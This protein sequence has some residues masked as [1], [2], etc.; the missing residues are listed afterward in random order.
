MVSE[1]WALA[2]A[3]LTNLRTLDLATGMASQSALRAHDMGIAVRWTRRVAKA[4][5]AGLRQLTHLSVRL[6][7][8]C[9]GILGDM[10][11]PL[12][13]HGLPLPVGGHTT[14][15]GMFI[16]G[17]SYELGARVQHAGLDL[18]ASTLATGCFPRLECLEF[19]LGAPGWLGGGFRLG[20]QLDAQAGSPL[21]RLREL[22]AIDP[23][24][25]VAAAARLPRLRCLTLPVD[26]AAMLTGLLPAL[27]SPPQGGD[28]HGGAAVA[29]TLVAHGNFTDLLAVVSALRGTPVALLTTGGASML[30]KGMNHDK[31]VRTLEALGPHAAALALPADPSRV[32]LPDTLRRRMG[33]LRELEVAYDNP[34][35]LPPMREGQAWD[36]HLR[37]LNLLGGVGCLTRLGLTLSYNGPD[38]LRENSRWHEAAD[39]DAHLG[40][41]VRAC[42]Q[43]KALDILIIEDKRYDADERERALASWRG[44]KAAAAAGAD[45]DRWRLAGCPSPV[46]SLHCLANLPALE[47]LSLEL[48]VITTQGL[49]GLVEDEVRTLLETVAKQRSWRRQQRAAAA[50]AA[51]QERNE[52]AA[53][54]PEPPLSVWC[55]Q[56]SRDAA[57]RLSRLSAQLTGWEMAATAA[58]FSS[59]RLHPGPRFLLLHA[60][61]LKG[62][63][64]DLGPRQLLQVGAAAYYASNT[65]AG[66][67]PTHVPNRYHAGSAADAATANHGPSSADSGSNNTGP[68][69]AVPYPVP[70]TQPVDVNARPSIFNQQGWHPRPTNPAQVH[71]QPCLHTLPNSR[72]VTTAVAP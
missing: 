65:A 49:S 31:L 66:A 12:Q 15:L 28:A 72:V 38:W 41:V 27:V 62:R 5:R 46:P 18:L 39:M 9:D 59:S 57:R 33:E 58:G 8:R 44:A 52:Q 22:L 68:T 61:A 67:V 45:L 51:G 47:R 71:D 2:L 25:G 29:T 56:L 14:H 1:D 11:L 54:G 7:L 55:P 17:Y 34:D 24:T 37:E 10:P 6:A 3:D 42:P 48:D 53:A 23:A 21:A 60:L 13:T 64:G 32:D 30:V 16:D 35:M 26:T 69:A 4:W 19:S 20:A 50:A 40:A 36:D 63:T 43:L 70:P